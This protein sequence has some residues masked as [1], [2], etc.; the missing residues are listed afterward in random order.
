MSLIQSSGQLILKNLRGVSAT[1]PKIDL[2]SLSTIF[3][4]GTFIY[5][6]YKENVKN[7]L[8]A[9]HGELDELYDERAAL[10]RDTQRAAS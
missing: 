5:G 9:F 6:S 3:L 8:V 2:M 1:P 10:F 4:S 7:H